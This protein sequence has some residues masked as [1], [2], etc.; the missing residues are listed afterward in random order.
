MCEKRAEQM[1]HQKDVGLVSRKFMSRN[2]HADSS[3]SDAC[4]VSWDFKAVG[5]D[6][7]IWDKFLPSDYLEILARA[8]DSAAAVTKKHAYLLLSDS[9]LL[10]D[11]GNLV[12][13]SFTKSFLS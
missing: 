6:D 7:E 11:H 3:L 2:K 12:F 8:V 4:N 9:P 5:D 1:K 13:L 10:L